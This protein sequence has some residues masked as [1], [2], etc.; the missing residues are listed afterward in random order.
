MEYTGADR[1]TPDGHVTP[2]PM[3]QEYTVISQAI[4]ADLV[5]IKENQ[6]ATIEL[7]TVFANTKG[8]IKVLQAMGEV[9]KWFTIVGSGVVALYWLFKK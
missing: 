3:L 5:A 2:C 7:L 6:K 4:H 9:V 8:F 1:R